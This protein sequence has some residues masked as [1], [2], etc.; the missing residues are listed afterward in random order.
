MAANPLG[1]RRRA[2]LAAVTLLAALLPL[3]GQAQAADPPTHETGYIPVAAGTLDE[4]QLH[5]KVTVPDPAVWGAGPYPTVIDY[6]GY[7]PALQGYDGLARRFRDAGYAVVGLNIR[8]SACS[9]GKFDY[10]EPRQS[11]DGVEALN[12][13]ADRPWSNGR[14]AMVGKSYPGITQLF[15]ASAR[16]IAG[17]GPRTQTWID[18]VLRDHLAA[19]VP[20]AVFADLYRDVPYPGGIQNVAFAGGWSASRAYEGFVVGPEAVGSGKAD[21]Q[22]LINQAQHAANPPFNPFVQAL[23]PQNNFDSDFF[24]SRSPFW[25]ADQIDTPTFLIESWQDEQ[26][27]SRAMHILERLKPGLPWKFLG[28]NGDHGEYYGSAV[29]PHILRFLSYHLKGVVPAGEERSVTVPPADAKPKQKPHPK[30]A[31]PTIR[32]ETFDEA[33]ARYV[34]EDRVIINWETG[35][36]GDRVPAWTQTYATW[37]VPSLTADRLYAR[38]DGTL[39]EDKPVPSG[40]FDYR[41][42]PGVGSQERGGYKLKEVPASS[43]DEKPP[44]GTFASFTTSALTEDKVLLGTASVDLFL[45]STAPDT[46]LEVTVSEIRSDRKEVFVQQGWLRASHRTEDPKLSTELRPFQTHQAVQSAA[47][48]P[49]IPSKLR[50]EVFP[51]GHVFR[52]GSQVRITIAAPHVK[53]DLWGFTLLPIPAI[54]SIHTGGQY[55]SSVALPLVAGQRAQVAALPACGGISVLRNQPCRPAD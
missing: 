51:F 33:L 32:P 10:F 37:P 35:A 17:D 53:P 47:L 12:W 7:L 9:S 4:A 16:A 13:L 41:Y 22:C 44:A 18:G 48:V 19:I 29:F 21:Q 5:Y 26:V 24:R 2:I 23:Q 34:A 27:G 36:G 43:W 14:F 42:T 45:S 46:D 31:T 25:F 49:T 30:D 15:V 28:T 55:A 1:M 11:V 38:P 54:N 8:G 52:A 39:S 40:R 3:L 6:S 50:V 20:G